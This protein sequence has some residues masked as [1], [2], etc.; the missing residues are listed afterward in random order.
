MRLLIYLGTQAGLG[1]AGDN[2]RHREPNADL[3]TQSH[4]SSACALMTIVN[5]PEWLPQLMP[6]L[7]RHESGLFA[8]SRL[9]VLG[10]VLCGVRFRKDLPG[11]LPDNFA[12][13]FQGMFSHWCDAGIS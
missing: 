10:P 5:H 7:C 2:N 3:D 12:G 4:E 8:P 13:V 6:V 11:T 1:G 9:G